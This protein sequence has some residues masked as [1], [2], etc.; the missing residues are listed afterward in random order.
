M[1]TLLESYG[2][3]LSVDPIHSPCPNSYKPSVFFQHLRNHVMVFHVQIFVE[4]LF[5]VE[6]LISEWERV[7]TFILNKLLE[8]FARI[9]F[10]HK[11]PNPNLLE[12]PD[13]DFYPSISWHSMLEFFPIPKIPFRDFYPFFSTCWHAFVPCRHAGFIGINN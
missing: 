11:S 6:L 2:S 13:R 12:F 5:D 8:L 3:W 9:L 7:T 10:V 4:S 1:Y